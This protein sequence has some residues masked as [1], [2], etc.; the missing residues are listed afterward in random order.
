M[1]PETVP[2]E[3]ALEVAVIKAAEDPLLYQERKANLAAMG[4]AP[5][6]VEQAR[7]APARVTFRLESE[8]VV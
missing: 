4:D 2:H 1:R 3:Q 6:G 7:V 5:P 8:V